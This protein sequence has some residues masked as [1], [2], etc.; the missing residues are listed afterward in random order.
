V[1]LPEPQKAT[2][3]APQAKAAKSTTAKP[4]VDELKP[5]ATGPT[6]KQ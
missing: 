1:G 6:T 3:P 5:T 2:T 4:K